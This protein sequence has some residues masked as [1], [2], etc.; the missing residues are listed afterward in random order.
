[1]TNDAKIFT[2]NQSLNIPP[3]HAQ[4]I[5]NKIEQEIKRQETLLSLTHQKVKLNDEQ[6]QE[7]EKIKQIRISKKQKNK[8]PVEGKWERLIRLRYFYEIQK[9]REQNFS[10]RAISEYMRQNHKKNIY[11]TTLKRAYEKISKQIQK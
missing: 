10:W 6:I 1:M 8:K 3:Q 4:E 2:L 7:I 11:F 9:L 5:L